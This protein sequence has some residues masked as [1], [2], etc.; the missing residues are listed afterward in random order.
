MRHR[1]RARA[2]RLGQARPRGQPPRSTGPAVAG[3]MNDPNDR[4]ERLHAL[5][6]AEPEAASG[7]EGRGIEGRLNRLCRA[8]ARS[9]PASG[10]GVTLMGRGEQPASTVAASS[11]RIRRLKDLQF[12]LGEGPCVEAYLSRRPVL[13]AN[14]ATNGMGRW[15]G[16]TL[17]LQER[18]VNAVFA[19]PL[20]VGAARLGV[21]D[22]YRD[23]AAGLTPA[24]LA[25]ALGFASLC[26]AT[27]L[28][29]GVGAD[30]Q[31]AQGLSDALR[32][33]SGVY[34]AQGKVMV[35]LGVS[36]PEAMARLRAH[37]Y[38]LNRLV[39]DVARDVLAGTIVF[40]PEDPGTTA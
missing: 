28:N 24:A 34:Q 11:P 36:L 3:L 30:G 22:V 9:L 17:A 33:S 26:L 5:V 25:D 38:A 37:A 15:P 29:G 12:V 39:G 27:L 32:V 13:E 20:Q 35:Q 14:L 16:Y 2:A 10:A 7:I 6:D 23:Q 19:F 21:L 1:A 40:T 8:A 31:L 4:L 18:G